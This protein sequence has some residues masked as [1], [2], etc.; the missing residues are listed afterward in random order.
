MNRQS[1]P[2]AQT[3]VV[4]CAKARTSKAQ[5]SPDPKFSAQGK[6]QGICDFLT[7][8]AALLLSKLHIL[9]ENPRQKVPAISLFD[10]PYGIREQEMCLRL[11]A[12]ERIRTV[13]A[14]RPIPSAEKSCLL[15]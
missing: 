14:V 5:T 8:K 7:A 2:A 15:W 4:P 12:A 6:L 1:S 13:F 11:E 10:F 3:K 9:L